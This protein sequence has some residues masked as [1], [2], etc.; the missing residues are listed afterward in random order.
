MCW[1]HSRAL[2]KRKL[3]LGCAL[4][5]SITWLSAK[6][7]SKV[8]TGQCQKLLIQAWM[9][10]PTR[11]LKE[12]HTGTLEIHDKGS[13]SPGA[14]TGMSQSN[15]HSPTK[16]NTSV[17]VTRSSAGK[18]STSACEDTYFS[19][20][21]QCPKPRLLQTAQITATETLQNNAKKTKPYFIPN[22]HLTIR[23][24]CLLSIETSGYTQSS[25]ST[26]VLVL[27]ELS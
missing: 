20:C 5:D 17:R 24:L 4:W 15:L 3:S 18:V 12:S 10:N 2:R 13:K 22:K 19:D 26:L 21:P 14:T 16:T 6:I 27:L 9:G 1:L 11:I 7:M 25:S 8:F 23:I